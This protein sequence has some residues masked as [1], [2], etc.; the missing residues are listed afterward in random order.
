MIV[1]FVGRAIGIIKMNTLKELCQHWYE[2]WYFESGSYRQY[3]GAT[4]PYLSM[5]AAKMAAKEYGGV[6]FYKL[7]Y[8]ILKVN[9]KVI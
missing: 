3:Q 9:R 7:P 6:E 4:G 8:E 1:V 2:I 5:V